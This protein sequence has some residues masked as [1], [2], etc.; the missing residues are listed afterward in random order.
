MG[1]FCA[2]RNA[3]G[4]NEEIVC[5]PFVQMVR[6]GN[7]LGVIAC[8]VGMLRLLNGEHGRRG[9]FALQHPGILPRILWAAGLPQE[10]RGDS[11]PA[12]FAGQILPDS[13]AAIAPNRMVLPASL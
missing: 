1:S 9:N 12:A 3:C 11:N 5:L 7:R 2:E 10:V 6:F 4:K 13:L 8:I